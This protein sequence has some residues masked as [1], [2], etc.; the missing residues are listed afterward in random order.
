MYSQ[1]RRRERYQIIYIWKVSQNMVSG[2]TLP[3]KQNP[4]LGRLV[5]LPPL[6]QGCSAS[7]RQAQEASL[8][9]KGAKLFN[10]LPRE[11][12]GLDDV[13]TDMFKSKLDDWLETIPDQPTISDRQRPAASNS[14]LD[15]VML[16]TNIFVA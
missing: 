15:Q 8:R 10:L 14:L 1:E 3:F 5:E 7:V 4:R 11:V 12:R 16:K 9:V 2:Y 6:S 13:T